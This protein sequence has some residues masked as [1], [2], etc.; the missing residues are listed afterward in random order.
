MGA[1]SRSS[2]APR[3]SRSCRRSDGARVT[4]PSEFGTGRLT[5]CQGRVSPSNFAVTGVER[6]DEMA[7]GPLVGKAI[8]VRVGPP[9]M[10]SRATYRVD[11]V[12]EV[13]HLL[14]N[15]ASAVRQRGAA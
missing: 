3:P 8:T 13:H 1:G 6:T 11:S 2:T 15:L 5:S 4:A 7:F 10:A 9:E 12:A 14:E